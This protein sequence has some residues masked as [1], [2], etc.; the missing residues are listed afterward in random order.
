MEKIQVGMAVPQRMALKTDRVLP[1]SGAIFESRASSDGATTVQAAVGSPVHAIWAGIV[2][3]V[4]ELASGEV[5]LLNRDGLHVRLSG[6]APSSIQ[7][8]RDDEVAAGVVLGTVDHRP[9]G[10]TA[11]TM[12]LFDSSGAFLDPVIELLGAVDPAEFMI[13]SSKMAPS[14]DISIGDDE[15]ADE[16]VEQV[17]DIVVD[18]GPAR[19]DQVATVPST[20]QA[21]TVPTDLGVGQEPDAEFDDDE[22][23]PE[24]AAWLRSQR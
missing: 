17:S 8:A 15:L 9:G 6:I 3:K 5:E 14:T 20:Q 21:D 12:R 7:V 2:N 23:D 1:V 4:D 13:R 18:A 19:P 11:L 24:L 22:D 10:P 16:L